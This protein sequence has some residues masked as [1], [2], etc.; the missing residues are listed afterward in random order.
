MGVESESYDPTT[1]EVALL[2]VSPMRY[3]T[4]DDPTLLATKDAADL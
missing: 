2:R 1:T 4:W 3:A